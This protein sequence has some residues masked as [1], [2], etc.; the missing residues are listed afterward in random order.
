[1]SDS[2][3]TGNTSESLPTHAT[4]ELFFDVPGETVLSLFSISL[5]DAGQFASGPKRVDAPIPECNEAE[6]KM[7][8]LTMSSPN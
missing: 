4:H 5:S 3:Q 8:F 6:V 1:M 2:S 7:R